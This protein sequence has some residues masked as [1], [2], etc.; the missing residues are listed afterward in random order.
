M[1]IFALLLVS[2]AACAQPCITATEACTDWVTLAGGPSRSLIYCTYSL[3][4]KNEKITRAL[5]VIH[6]TNRDADNY[7]RSTLAAAFLADALEDTILIVPH[8]ASAS[9]GCRDTLAPHEVS[10][11]LG[12]W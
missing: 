9:G 10:W 2:V 12:S 7:F 8:I 6:G 3:D 5:I 11:N 4:A 1:R